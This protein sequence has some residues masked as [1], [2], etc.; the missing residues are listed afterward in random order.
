MV[1]ND[2]RPSV[3][4]TRWPAVVTA[5]LLGS[6]LGWLIFELPDRWGWQL[7]R[8]PLLGSGAIAVLALG[9]GF[10][11]WGTRRHVQ[12]RR[13]TIP[14]ARAV[15][16]LALGKTAILA[17]VGMAGG[18][19]AVIVMFVDRLAAE[20]ARERVI[21]ATIAVVGAIGLAIAGAFLERALRSPEPPSADATP[22]DVP[23]SPKSPH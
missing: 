1:G 23:L 17:G 5:L 19:A 9:V 4:A 12:Y 20:L 15:M 6:G 18:Y 3:R 10:L 13:E 21:N 11:A 14:R 2:P 8:L 7:P 22:N 16:L